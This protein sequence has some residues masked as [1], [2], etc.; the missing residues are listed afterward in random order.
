MKLRNLICLWL[1]LFLLGSGAFAQ[2]AKSDTKPQL[3][4]KVFAGWEKTADD[5][6]GSDPS[7]VDPASGRILREYGFTDYETATY[8]QGARKLSLK[9]ARFQDASGAY[10]A[11]TFY[12]APNMQP[13]TI[14][15]LAASA[16]DRVLF[17]ASNVL[18]MAQFD[19]V[20]ATSAGE[21]RELTKDLPAISGP[22]SAL[23]SLPNY[24][25]RKDLVTNSAKFIV[26]PE[27]LAM[28]GAPINAAA[29]DFSK[30]PEVLLGD[31]SQDGN[32]AELVL[33]NYPTPEIAGARLRAIEEANPNQPD[34]TFQVK[35]T[36]PIVALVKGNL[37]Q[38]DAKVL[39]GRIN[40]E[41]EV[42]WNENAGNSKKDNIG[43]LVIAASILAGTIFLISV[44]TGGL[45]GIGRIFFEK[46]FPERYAAHEQKTEFIKL[47]LRD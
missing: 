15:A 39:L 7:L 42:T 35:R 44:V 27:A 13:E 33:I 46:F 40:Y 16:N 30:Q 34:T 3:L 5:K 37:S 21:L 28:V 10:G 11:F 29:V 17:F 12:R 38:S 8:A 45:F 18:V 43:N 41:A 32:T 20:T 26:G 47:H 31:Y 22:A 9:A 2:K 23:P 14:G 4:P 19:H 1:A 36:G 25:P 24:L 6:T